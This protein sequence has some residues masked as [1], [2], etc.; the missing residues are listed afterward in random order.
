MASACLVRCIIL[1]FYIISLQ[2]NEFISGSDGMFGSKRYFTCKGDTALFVP[3]TQCKPDSRLQF[4]LALKE[5]PE[6]PETPSG[7][8]LLIFYFLKYPLNCCKF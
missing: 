6:P 4:S 1:S 5:I 2:D 7:K 3:L 8:T